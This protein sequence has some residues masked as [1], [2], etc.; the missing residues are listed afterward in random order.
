M[1]PPVE[2]TSEL[3]TKPKTK[4]SAD[5]KSASKKTSVKSAAKAAAKPVKSAKSA[6]PTKAA[7]GDDKLRKQLEKIEKQVAEAK[8]RQAALE[9]SGK[10]LPKLARALEKTRDELENFRD[11]TRTYF[12]EITSK[13]EALA[14]DQKTQARVLD[15]LSALEARLEGAA[16]AS[17]KGA[18]AAPRSDRDVVGVKQELQELR[19]WVTG[20]RDELHAAVREVRDEARSARSGV[21]E[22]AQRGWHPVGWQEYP[23]GVL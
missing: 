2:G 14:G 20:L 8:T 6:K 1:N 11:W 3:A 17:T 10:D 5:K 23:P 18:P 15:R 4:K 12:E 7:A 13:F 22:L 9:K 21:D 16:P 19:H